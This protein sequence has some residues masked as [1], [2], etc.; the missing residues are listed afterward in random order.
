[1]AKIGGPHGMIQPAHRI[2]K[3]GRY[4]FEEIARMKRED[5]RPAED[6]FDLGVGSPDQPPDPAIIEMMAKQLHARPFEN[7]RYSSFDGAPEFRRA[8]ANWYKR[9]FN[10]TVDPDKE[11]LPLIGSKDGISKLMLAYLD[12]GDT[13]VVATPC[14]PAYLGAAKIVEANVVELP[15]RPENNYLPDFNAVPHK[16]WDHAKFLF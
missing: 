16:V 4:V 3:T 15:L 5:P 6:I 10:V 12:P 8:V 7:H 9:R 1:M 14:Y 11:V 2:Q 13:I